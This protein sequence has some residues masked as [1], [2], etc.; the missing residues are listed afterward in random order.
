MSDKSK[1]SK[2]RCKSGK[3]RRQQPEWKGK[4]TGERCKPGK[5]L[6]R[7]KKKK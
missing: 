7:Q 5:C 4:K 2:K 1:K 6:K 3:C